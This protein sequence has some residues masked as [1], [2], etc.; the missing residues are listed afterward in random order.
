MAQQENSKKRSRIYHAELDQYTRDSDE[1]KVNE[2]QREREKSV[3]VYIYYIK[4]SLF[5]FFYSS[6]LHCDS[7]P[8]L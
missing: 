2:T 3:E 5:Y 8:P 4:L 7:N 1:N 6:T